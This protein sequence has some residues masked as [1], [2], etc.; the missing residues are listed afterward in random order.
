MTVATA[1]VG[2]RD[3]VAP[4]SDVLVLASGPT[5]GAT[6]STITDTPELD[7]FSATPTTPGTISASPPLSLA[8]PEGPAVTA[9]DPPNTVAYVYHSM[10]TSSAGTLFLG[11]TC[12]DSDH[13]YTFVPDHDYI[14]GLGASV[15]E[16]ITFVFTDAA[17]STNYV[18]TVN[19]AAE[20]TLILVR[21]ADLTAG[22]PAANFDVIEGSTPGTE[23]VEKAFDDNTATKY[24]NYD[25]ELRP[26]DATIDM[27]GSTIVQGLGLTTAN[28]DP[29]R[30]PVDLSLYGSTLPFTGLRQGSLL[31][32]VSTSSTPT[33]VTTSA[34]GADYGDFTFTNTTAYRY[35]QVVFEAVEDP[36]GAGSMQIA[37]VR[38]PGLRLNDAPVYRLNGDPATVSASMRLIGDSPFT[39]VTMQ[40]TDGLNPGYDVLDV[41][42]LPAGVTKSYDSSTG[43][44]TLTST[45]ALSNAVIQ[46]AA[47]LVTYWSTASSVVVP[48]ASRAI[49]VTV[50]AADS[51]TSSAV[52]DLRTADRDVEWSTNVATLTY[53]QPLAVSASPSAGGGTIT[54]TT[55]GNCVYDGGMLSASTAASPASC[56]LDAEVGEDGTYTTVSAQVPLGLTIAKAPL[57]VTAPSPTVVVGSDAG[58]LTPTYSGFVGSD[59][60]LDTAPTCVTTY[61]TASDTG[62][63]PVTC[64]GGSDVDYAPSYVAGTLTAVSGSVPPPPPSTVP[65]TTVPSSTVPPTTTP[66]ETPPTT[67][68]I[69]TP[70]PVPVDSATGE[71]PQLEPGASQVFEDGL[72]EVV[73]IFIESTT[74][75]TEDP[76]ASG[77]ELVMRGAGFEVRLGVECA[78]GCGVDSDDTGRQVLKV[79]EDGGVSV[80]G[81][82]FRA[83]SQV[84]VWIFSDPQYLGEL[85]V[86]ADGTFSGSLPMPAIGVGEHTLQINGV[87]SNGRSRSANLGVVVDE[88]PAVPIGVPVTLPAT[89]STSSGWWVW[90]LVIAVLG[91]GVIG[92]RRRLNGETASPPR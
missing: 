84:D 65:S 81:E 19:G 42:A 53:G 28:D 86:A 12:P 89:G 21:E 68:P 80:A 10:A 73:E 44:L 35:Y 56:Q 30:D 39:T 64:S 33:L 18:I 14:N 51:S 16:T 36:S 47:R 79:T 5:L 60:A 15:T 2:A 49:T 91:A 78:A 7:V 75:D 52:I 40:I 77:P 48:Q 29:R 31:F 92:M 55:T 66:T 13:C 83:D 4:A 88:A 87:G 11:S 67:V 46:D 59:V 17:G 74:G 69:T 54:Y 57:T 58:T 90:S 82:G 25:G 37:E 6:A 62:T 26:V 76:S 71:L 34:R 72:P 8:G 27:G 24:L 20:D 63:Y 3:P 41:A 70:S 45:S 50:T 22:L 85:T 32:R 38:L 23:G 1:S 61:T 9:V 43:L